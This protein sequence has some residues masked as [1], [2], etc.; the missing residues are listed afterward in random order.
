MSLSPA[1][2]VS[3]TP[4]AAGQYDV[5]LTV[6][7][8]AVPQNSITTL[9]QLNVS[10]LP[11][12]ALTLPS[13]VMEG[14]GIASGAVSIPAALPND[15]TVNLTSSDSSKLTVPTSVTIPAG[16]LSAPL[17]LTVLDDGLLERR[18]R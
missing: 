13:D 3:G 5:A 14:I 16:Q 10:S 18:K 11:L 2:V 17:P 8:S 6:T 1:G 7:D 15:L 4:T 12:V 9:L